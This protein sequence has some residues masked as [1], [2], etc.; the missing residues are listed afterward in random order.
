MTLCVCS[1]AREVKGVRAFNCTTPDSKWGCT[2]S[3][4][5][6]CEVFSGVLGSNLIDAA[7]IIT[8]AVCPE[9]H[10]LRSPNYKPLVKIHRLLWLLLPLG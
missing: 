8:P 1:P 4:R 2:G 10:M 3:R 7:Q 5:D 9:A 6:S